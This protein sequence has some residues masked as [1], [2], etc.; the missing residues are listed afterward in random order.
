[1]PGERIITKQPFPMESF[2]LMC[3][4]M[5]SIT[6]VL[7]PL[8]LHH[9]YIMPVV[10]AIIYSLIQGETVA[11]QSLC[12]FTEAEPGCGSSFFSGLFPGLSSKAAPSLFPQLHPGC[13]GVLKHL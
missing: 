5:S 11:L 9:V 6:K 4:V 2:L 8:G 13:V 12:K 10:I 1:M 3:F 7:I